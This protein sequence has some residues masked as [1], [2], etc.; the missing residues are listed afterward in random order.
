MKKE[1]S[2]GPLPNIEAT[3]PTQREILTGQFAANKKAVLW[4]T[5]M[6][7][8]AYADFNYCTLCDWIDFMLPALNGQRQ[9]S[10]RLMDSELLKKWWY[11]NWH[12]ADDSFIL[13]Y[14]YKAEREDCLVRYRR[15]HQYVFDRKHT[16][17][18]Y[19]AEDFNTLL[20]DFEKE[21]AN[22]H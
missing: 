12:L 8:Q 9:N 2:T 3:G 17:F 10:M 18:K 6:S 5:G 13:D 7:E 22:E 1:N 4:L 14:L 20:V 21:V 11:Y 16:Y 15:L 19:L